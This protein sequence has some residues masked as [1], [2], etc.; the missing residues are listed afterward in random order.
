MR[1]ERLRLVMRFFSCHRRRGGSGRAEVKARMFELRAAFDLAKFRVKAKKIKNLLVIHNS[2]NLVID[3]GPTGRQI[4]RSQRMYPTCSFVTVINKI[5]I[6]VR[7]YVHF[8]VWRQRRF[9]QVNKGWRRGVVLSKN[10]KWSLL[11][12]CEI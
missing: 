4:L 5:A 1:L 10:C 9:R 11:M 7:C 3:F 8:P 6:A 12:E 2:V